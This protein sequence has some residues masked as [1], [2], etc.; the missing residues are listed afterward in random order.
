LGLIFPHKIAKF[1]T[2]VIVEF[3]ANTVLT[4]KMLQVTEIYTNWRE[5]IPCL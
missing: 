2:R 1:L 4:Y 3:Q 5:K